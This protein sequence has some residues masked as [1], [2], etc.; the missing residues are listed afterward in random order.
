MDRTSMNRI[1][2]LS[3]LVAAVTFFATFIATGNSPKTS[4]T[5]ATIATFY[6][7]HVTDIEISQ[8]LLFIFA[9]A[10]LIYAAFL[11][12]RFRHAMSTDTSLA[13]LVLIGGALAVVVTLIQNGV[14]MV[15]TMEPVQTVDSGIAGMYGLSQQ[16]YL[17]ML[18]SFAVFLGV[19]A[20]AALETRALPTWLAW[21]TATLSVAMFIFEAYAIFHPNANNGGIGGL[22]F[23]VFML[24]LIVSSIYCA[25]STWRVKAPMT[26]SPPAP[27]MD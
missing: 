9:F 24:W 17:I 21:I 6:K 14:E 2:A 13:T 25:R 18:F 22:L 12:D 15:L 1:G 23:I 26:A 8:L 27:A 10:L 20:L 16:L 11:W 7:N 3:G 5:A 4:A 19:V